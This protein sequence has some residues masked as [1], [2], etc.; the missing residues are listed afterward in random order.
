MHNSWMRA[1][2]GR[3]K[4]DY[5]YSA[6]IVYNNFPFPELVTDKSRSLIERAAKTVIDIRASFPTW[7][8]GE[9]YDPDQMPP[10]LVA[11]H[12]AL[13]GAVDSCYRKLPFASEME[14]VRYLFEL[15]E[16]RTSPRAMVKSW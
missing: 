7:T 8:L 5:Q 10:K 6:T 2:A 11:A 3:M 16:N 13:D 1:V 15:Y 9:L 12:A 14:R 4:S